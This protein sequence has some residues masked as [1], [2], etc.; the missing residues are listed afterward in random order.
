MKKIIS[1]RFAVGC[2]LRGSWE[3]VPQWHFL[4]IKRQEKQREGRS[5]RGN[6]KSPHN[7]NTLLSA[8]SLKKLY[9]ILLSIERRQK[10]L[11]KV[12]GSVKLI[13][14]YLFVAWCNNRVAKSNTTLPGLQWF[15]YIICDLR[16]LNSNGVTVRPLLDLYSSVTLW[17]YKQKYSNVLN[18][19]SWTLNRT[20]LR[21]GLT[22]HPGKH[23]FLDTFFLSKQVTRRAICDASLCRVVVILHYV[24]VD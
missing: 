3:E 1:D 2:V 11:M 18:L 5:W 9:S 17:R 15:C 12:H 19:V 6:L 13:N 22:L 16:L 24:C 10:E 14:Y 8:T 20:Q 21:R 23:H 7:C 4:L